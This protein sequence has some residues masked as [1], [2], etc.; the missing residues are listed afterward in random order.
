LLCDLALT[1]G[2]FDSATASR[3]AARR[4]DLQ[5]QLAEALLLPWQA[6]APAPGIKAPL[7]A[8]LLRQYGDLRVAPARWRLVH[9]SAAAVMHRWLTEESVAAYF[10]LAHRS[11]S[12]ER[13]RLLERQEFWMSRLDTIDGAWLLAARQPSTADQI[14]HGRLGGRSDQVGL[15]LRIGNLTVLEIAHESSERIWF[16]GNPLAPQLYRQA[17]HVYW[18]GSLAQGVDFSSAFGAEGSLDWQGRVAEFLDRGS[19][20]KIA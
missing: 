12:V 15:L 6:E 3:L 17:D 13:T 18:P 8:F 11:K 19:A 10:A 1:V 14:A 4:A 2:V 9:R 20:G 5:T 7:M 16:K